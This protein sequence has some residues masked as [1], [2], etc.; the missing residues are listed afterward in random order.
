MSISEIN[1][2]MI[3]SNNGNMSKEIELK[4]MNTNITTNVMAD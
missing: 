1:Y 4:T 3:Y 2:E